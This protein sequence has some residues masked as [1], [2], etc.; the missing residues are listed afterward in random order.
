MF[1]AAS[2]T[3]QGLSFATIGIGPNATLTANAEGYAY[4]DCV[5]RQILTISYLGY[6]N[7][8]LSCEDLNGVIYLQPESYQMET[9]TITAIN[10]TL[11]DKVQAARIAMKA[12]DHSITKAYLRVTTKNQAEP[13]EFLQAYYNAYIDQGS[14]SALLLKNGKVYKNGMLG[15]GSLAASVLPTISITKENDHLEPW[16]SQLSARKLL[17]S[18]HLTSRGT[19]GDD[20]ILII[21]FEPLKDKEHKWYG[22]IWID[23]KTNTFLKLTYQN[24]NLIKHPFLPLHNPDSICYL[25]PSIVILLENNQISQMHIQYEIEYYRTLA[26]DNPQLPEVASYNS[27]ISL[28]ILNE[29]PFIEPTLVYDPSYNDYR[30]ISLIPY[31]ER[32]WQS[33]PRP[34]LSQEEINMETFFQDNGIQ[35]PIFDGFVF[36]TQ[37][38]VWNKNKRWTLIPTE[39]NK[40]TQDGYIVRRYDLHPA[41]ILDINHDKEGFYFNTTTIMDI[42]KTKY[43]LPNTPQHNAF[44]NIYFDLV[45]LQRVTLMSELET[46]ANKSETSLMQCYHQQ[47][48][49]LNTI[50][51]KYLNEVNAGENLEN[52][53]KYNDLIYEKLHINNF[54]HFGLFIE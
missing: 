7:I 29:P 18:Y 43:A 48:A 6:K 54:S 11:Y 24:K 15:F 42:F 1:I 25:A 31:N 37:N 50:L 20:S 40:T 45:E 49:K 4:I 51:K 10:K 28:F 47:I 33:Q 53:K 16:P 12:N 52:L 26:I 36:Q 22:E 8:Q 13:V 44:L 3:K 39:M 35:L 9:V 23:N 38:I 32:F 17:K 27:K 30:K 19:I 2:D 14:I 46:L 34:P 5:N 21:G 41:I